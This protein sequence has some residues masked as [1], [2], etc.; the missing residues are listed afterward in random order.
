MIG[1]K[2]LIEIIFA[3]KI[4]YRNRKHVTSSAYSAREEPSQV[5]TKTPEQGSRCGS[6]SP[7]LSHSHSA[8]TPH[9]EKPRRR[10][11]PTCVEDT[12]E[13]TTPPPS[14]IFRGSSSP[15]SEHHDGS[16]D[17]LSADRLS[18]D[19]E[20]KNDLSGDDEQAKLEELV[21]GKTETRS[22]R[23]RKRI[24]SLSPIRV[25]LNNRQ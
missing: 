14:P 3:I 15:H 24:P 21:C 22:T 19:N 7:Q 16:P 12:P 8:S 25:K 18:T 17:K 4:L 6:S 5:I 10:R 1:S 11:L 2:I 13:R 9:Q 23:R 20:D